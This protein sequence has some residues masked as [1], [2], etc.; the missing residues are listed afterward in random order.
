MPR[1]YGIDVAV[2]QPTNL[3]S[4]VSHGAKFV[5][6]K[7]TEGTNYINPKAVAQI[8]SAHAN[9]IYVHAYHFATFGNSVSRAKAEARYFIQRAKYLNISKKR[10]LALDWETGDGNVVTGS[11]SANTKA[12]VAFL[13]EIKQAG[14]KPMLYSGA[15]LLRNNIEV[16]TI[17]RK[18]GTCIWVASYPTMAPVSTAD[19]NWF[20]SMEGVAIWQF[21]SNWYGLSVDANVSLINLHSDKASKSSKIN[22]K[23]ASSA[24]KSVPKVVYAPIIN[25]NRNWKIAL[26][27]STGHLTG[28]YIPTDSRWKVFDAKTIKGE[29]YYKLGNNQQWVPAKY[30]K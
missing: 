20:P 6:V 3:A 14:Y 15:S 1:E 12:I 21:S 25:G 17:V 8:R 11:R 13:A 9:H 7:A 24:H 26:R 22:T 4:Y 2:Y 28:K 19:F 27:D 5:F 16:S 29:K 23:N 10:Y 18:F 30:V